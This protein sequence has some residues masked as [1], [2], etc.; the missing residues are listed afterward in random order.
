MVTAFSS[1]PNAGKQ[2]A[3]TDV[4]TPTEAATIKQRVDDFNTVIQA[5]A[6]QRDIPVADIKGLFDRLATRDPS[7]A[8]TGINVGPITLSSAF[9]TGGAFS[10][11]GFHMS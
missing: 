7:G 10:L 5:A 4:L 11:D 1:L 2:L 9:I 3:D 8:L 6:Q